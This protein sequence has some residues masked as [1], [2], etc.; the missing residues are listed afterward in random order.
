[1]NNEATKAFSSKQENLI[2][3]DLGWDVVSGSGA[4]PTVP[5]DVIS[6]DWLGE[7]K[8]HVK[9]GQSILFSTEVWTKIC[10]EALMK[11][12]K[13]VLFVD[14]GS[15]KLDNTWV[16]CYEH[17]IDNRNNLIVPIENFRKM[18]KNI[19]FKNEVGQKFM[20][21]FIKGLPEDV[22]NV[23]RYV[24]FSATWARSEVV[25]MTYATFKELY[26]K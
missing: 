17:S 11:H 12:R 13:P 26:N 14:D 7:C 15:Q 20:K 1:M 5:G 19:T 25:V 24:V 16:M 3:Y 4:R 22:A 9:P 18:R 23:Y 10:Q 2:S 21:D 6:D 8:T